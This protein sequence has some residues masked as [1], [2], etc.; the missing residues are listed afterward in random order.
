MELSIIV[1]VYNSENNLEM[2]ITRLRGVL[3]GLA[4]SYEVVLVNDGSRDASWTCICS[5]A[6]VHPWIRGMNLMR[7][8]GQ[9]NA[10]LCGIRAARGDVIVTLDDDLQHPPEEIHKLLNKLAEGFDVVY[11]SPRVLPHS[12]GRNLFSRFT[13]RTLA[14]VMGLRTV[15]DIGSFRAFHS[16]L[17]LAFEGYRNPNVL[18]DVLLSWGTARFGV[19]QVEEEQR[20][21]GHSNYNF[22]KLFQVAMK[23]L[24]GFSTLPLRITSIIGF[25]FTLFGLLIFLYVLVI[26][27]TAGSIPGFPFLAS[28]ISIFSGTQLFALGIIG[29]YLARIFDRSM[30][31]P[32]YVIGETTIAR[33]G[34]ALAGERIEHSQKA[35]GER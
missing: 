9:H 24:T 7:N 21:L 3:P 14:Y 20:S 25:L 8:Y 27:F 35:V 22:L 16:K 15:Q 10:L 34:L 33:E 18:I 31:R 6:E 32:A 1:P 28:I 11:G 13:K 30:D 4:S 26:S 5:L 12:W 29:E 17:R 19:V 23:V 2:L